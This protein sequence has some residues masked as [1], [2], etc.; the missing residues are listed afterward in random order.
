MVGKEMKKSDL[1]TMCWF[2][3]GVV[4]LLI[5]ECEDKTPRKEILKKL[6]EHLVDVAEA[7]TE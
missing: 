5:S 2:Y 1:Y 7:L 6:S 3:K 4:D